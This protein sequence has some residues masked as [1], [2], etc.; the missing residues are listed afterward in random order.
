[1]A[2][3]KYGPPLV[4]CALH[5]SRATCYKSDASVDAQKKSACHGQA[6]QH[7]EEGCFTPGEPLTLRR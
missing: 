2:A 5:I 7:R 4:G 6:N 3:Q 1:M